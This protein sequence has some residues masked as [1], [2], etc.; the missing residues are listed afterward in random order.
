MRTSVW[1]TIF[2]AEDAL[3]EA[4]Q[5][6]LLQ[7]S[8]RIADKVLHSNQ[9]FQ[10]LR[11]EWTF[12]RA[13]FPDAVDIFNTAHPPLVR[14]PTSQRSLL[15]ESRQNYYDRF[16]QYLEVADKSV[17]YDS[18]G[19]KCLIEE[20]CVDCQNDHTDDNPRNCFIARNPRF[21]LSLHMFFPLPVHMQH[22]DI[23]WLQQSGQLERCDI[24]EQIPFDIIMDNDWSKFIQFVLQVLEPVEVDDDHHTFMHQNQKYTCFVT[25]MKLSDVPNQQV[26]ACVADTALPD[27]ST[28]CHNDDI[29]LVLQATPPAFSHA[30]PC[31]VSAA[32]QNRL[33]HVVAIPFLIFLIN[34]H[35]SYAD[36]CT[37]FRSCL[38]ANVGGLAHCKI[39]MQP[40]A[41][42]VLQVQEN[43]TIFYGALH[44]FWDS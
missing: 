40:E 9:W 19:L 25:E 7:W 23:A 34:E 44:Y 3:P 5:K 18:L 2:D 26:V 4:Q 6:H 33:L 31:C 29:C 27:L 21:N 22:V 43:G 39:F 37:V 28:L 42:S 20:F 30:I 41:T 15:H 24:A 8:H 10:S 13:H 12:M 14:Q 32:P 1:N 35:S 38:P 16:V 36:V 11:P 17:V